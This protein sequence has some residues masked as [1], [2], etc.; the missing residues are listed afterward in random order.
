MLAPVR[1]LGGATSR[2]F[3]AAR[4]R[5][6]TCSKVPTIV[7]T[8][9]AA[10]RSLSR[11]SQWQLHTKEMNEDMLRS[12]KVNRQRLMED[13]HHT[14]KWGTGQRWGKCATLPSLERETTVDVIAEPTLKQACL[15]SHFL[16]PT[17]KLA[18]GL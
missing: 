8:N 17:K 2:P 14:C 12:L 3:A 9:A 15:V 1:A 4:L 10:R 11:S 6:Q 5:V 18:T 13:I 7:V 16:I